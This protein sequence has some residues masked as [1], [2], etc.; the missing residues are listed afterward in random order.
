MGKM[1][2]NLERKFG[3]Y[4]IRN[5]SLVMICCFIFG[6]LLQLIEKTLDR[7][8]LG[9]LTL[10]PYLI[11]HGQVWRLVS[12]L[13]IPPE[14]FGVFTLI[15][16]YFYFSIGRS[17]E[18]VWG[19]F[20][21]NFYIFSGIIFTII[22]AFVLYGI[23]YIVF[24]SELAAGTYTAHDLFTVGAVYN[25]VT[26]V[27][28]YFPCFWFSRVST[29]YVCMSI[30]LAYA[31][32]F[33]EMH[34][35][36]MFFIPVKVKVLGIIYAAVLGFQVFEYILYG[37]YYMAVIILASLL[38]ALIF[39]LSTRNYNKIS[40]S[41]IKRRADYKRKVKWAG[42]NMGHQSVHDGKNVITRHK[43]AICGRTELDGENL[44]FRFCSKC[45]GNYEYCQDHLYTHEHVK[46][47]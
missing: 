35:M 39:F 44:E 16:L 14:S 41:E 38:N 45:D 6:Y 26:G 32:T 8:I 13:V 15:M 47:I 5:L 27:T 36:L 29:Y 31:I 9:Y 7:D 10:N 23:S 28:T 20:R 17:L 11:L 24:S 18:S 12:W 42:P 33:P 1:L 3:Q 37:Q 21:Y 25:R 30:F 22:G 34:V 19:D 4:A 40:P 46:R 2:F 43:C